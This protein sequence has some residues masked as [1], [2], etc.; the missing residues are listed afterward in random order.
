MVELASRREETLQ[1]DEPRRLEGEHAQPRQDA[2]DLSGEVLEAQRK[3]PDLLRH[4]DA[5]RARLYADMEAKGGW[6]SDN[7]ADPDC[8]PIAYFS[9]D[10]VLH[11]SLPLFAGGLGLLSG[12]HLKECS[13]LRPLLVAIGL[14]Y[15]EGYAR[16]K[17]RVDGGTSDRRLVN[18]SRGHVKSSHGSTQR[19]AK[20]LP[21]R[22][23]GT[24]P[25]ARL[26]Q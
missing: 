10:Y 11:R 7:L 21:G 12:D 3:E 2:P 15:P 6:Y 1:D 17:I 18:D 16:Q 22:L 14:M 24:P 9:A 25:G 4:F 23:N 8:L 13:D 26:N 5:A 20:G 19:L